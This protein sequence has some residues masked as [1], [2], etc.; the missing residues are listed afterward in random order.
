MHLLHR[1][2][3]RVHASLC[4]LPLIYNASREQ[5]KKQVRTAQQTLHGV[6]HSRNDHHSSSSGRGRRG[7]RMQLLLRKA[8]GYERRSHKRHSSS[9][10]SSSKQ[11]SLKKSKYKKTA[12]IRERRSSLITSQIAPHAGIYKIPAGL[13]SLV[14]L[15]LVYTRARYISDRQRFVPEAF[16]ATRYHRKLR[17]SGLGLASQSNNTL[18]IC[19]VPHLLPSPTKAFCSLAQE[20]SGE[21]LG[22]HPPPS[23]AAAGL[24]QVPF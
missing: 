5:Q 24:G 10:S 2:G 8:G 17:S 13:S 21:S 9:S 16:A 7:G 20:T 23:A 4:S 19:T 22:P 14:L 3:E 6:E 15:Q 18:C 11:E 1:V 12:R